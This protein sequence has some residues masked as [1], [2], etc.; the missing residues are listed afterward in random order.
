MVKLDDEGDRM[1]AMEGGPW[2][3]FDHC[4]AVRRWFPEFHPEHTK[5]DKTLVYVRF[6]GLNL[7]WYDESFLM[8]MAAAIGMPLRVDKTML[9]VTRGHF[10]RVCMEIDM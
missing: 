5:V 4:L 6:M 2:M 8:A 10:A 1:K 3:M 7:L 9:G